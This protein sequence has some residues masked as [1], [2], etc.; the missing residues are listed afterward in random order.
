[1]EKL[2]VF[3]SGLGGF[4]VVANLRKN[5]DV[6][7][8]FLADHKNLPYGEKTDDELKTILLNNMQWFEDQG[9]NHVLIACNTASA[10]VEYLRAHK[11]QMQIDSII[12]ITSKQLDGEDLII[13]GTSKTVENKK[14]DECLNQTHTYKALSQLASLVEENDEFAIMQYLK[15][16]L[17]DIQQNQNYL[18]GCTHYSIVQEMFKELLPG[19]YFDSIEPVNNY[20]ANLSGDN[21]L[22]IYSTGNIKLLSD[23]LLNI[24][25]YKVNV[26]PHKRDFKI[27][28]VSDNHGLYAPLLEVLEK[29]H[30]ASVFIHCGDVELNDPIMNQFYTVNGN[31]DY[32]VR[33]VDNIT[34][35]IYDQVYY[36]THGHEYMRQ[37]R[38]E[39]LYNHG[40]LINARAVFYGHEHIFKESYIDEML[41]LNP[42]SLFYNRDKMDPSYAIIEVSDEKLIVKRQGLEG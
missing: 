17:A 15:A 32:L 42:G 26:L 4:N 35:N 40:K 22:E 23:Q 41:L 19:V 34:L 10:Y 2:G 38:L 24:F 1:M 20:Y 3:D 29:H 9:I 21:Q 7:I 25:D 13:F 18:L 11:P 37:G 5:S 8:V 31:N 16:E 39:N 14:Y 12:E 28:L 6:D 27:V 30:D 36:I 33:Y